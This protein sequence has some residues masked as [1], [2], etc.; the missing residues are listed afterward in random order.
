M[1]SAVEALTSPR[2]QDTGLVGS[3]DRDQ[4]A[5]A[6]AAGRVL[7]TQDVD[8]LRLHAE[9]VPHAGIVY[10]ADQAHSVGEMLRRLV[11]I[12]AALSTEEMKNRVEYL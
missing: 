7:V 5:F 4:L 11:L 8:F 9:S 6:T 2:P 12:N 3:S 10:F 1:A